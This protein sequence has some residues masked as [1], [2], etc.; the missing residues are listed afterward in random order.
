MTLG[1]GY[2]VQ[3][4]MALMVSAMEDRPVSTLSSGTITSSAA[5]E[6]TT[7]LDPSD[8]ALHSGGSSFVDGMPLMPSSAGL[9]GAVGASPVLT[10][11]QK[12][13]RYD[14][15]MGGKPWPTPN[16]KPYYKIE[17]T[18]QGEPGNIFVGWNAASQP[19]SPPG[20]GG[21]AEIN[22]GAMSYEE[23]MNYSPAPL[24]EQLG[25]LR[26]TFK[27]PRSELRP[28]FGA[29]GAGAAMLPLLMLGGLIFWLATRD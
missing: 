2:E 26:G 16:P 9:A 4:D 22:V 10:D 17:P 27:E 1:A 3:S 15:R 14:K 18:V 28:G 25:A 21:F 12:W 5:L 23:A 7:G 24:T 20:M 29:A 8:G 19:G 11:I 13:E 6:V